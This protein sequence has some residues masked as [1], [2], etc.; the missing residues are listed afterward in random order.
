V[1]FLQKQ[2]VCKEA[3][4]DYKNIHMKNFITILYVF[5]SFFRNGVCELVS[6]QL[7]RSMVDFL[8]ETG[9][10]VAQQKSDEHK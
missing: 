2:P 3:I 4:S 5:E 6:R 10:V 1:H 9:I 7:I 8:V